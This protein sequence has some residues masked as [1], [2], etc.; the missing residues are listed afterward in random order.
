MV[1]DFFN[2]SLLTRQ[3]W[4]FRKEFMWI[5]VF[6]MI[7]NVLMLTPTIYMLQLYARVLKSH[8]DLTLLALT[9]FMLL[10]FLV[11]AF[12]EW[13]RSRLLV[14]IGVRL[15]EGLNSLVFNAS[16]QAF[17]SNAGKNVAQTF[18]DLASIRQ[19]LTTNGTIAFFDVPWTPVYIGVM[20][21]LHPIL[22]WLALLFA[23]VQLVLTWVSNM[24]V[25]ASIELAANEGTKGYSFLQGKLRNIEPVHAMG[26]TANLRSRWSSLHDDY[27]A[28]SSSMSDRQHRLE[29]LNKLVRYSISSLTLA[30]GAILVIRGEL[31]VGSM[32]AANVLMSKAL[33][34]LDL[35]IATLQPF[36]KARASFIRLEKLLEDF[37]ERKPGTKML[38]DPLGEITLRNLSVDVPGREQPILKDISTMI[39]AGKVTVILGPTGSGKSTLARCL[40][41]V[42]PG[43]CD[44][45]LI[46]GEPVDSWDR[47]QLGRNIGYLPQ[48]IEL[49]EGTFA[50]NISRFSEVDSQKVIEAAKRAGI[51]DMIV[52]FPKGYD[53]PIGEAGGLLSAGQRQRLGLARAMYGN[54]SIYVLDEPNANLDEIGERALIDAVKNLKA[55]GKTVIM[56]SHRTGILEAADLVMLM[57]DGRVDRFG[58]KQDVLKQ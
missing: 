44:Q 37:P 36:V 4:L 46:D 5:G 38:Q 30:A 33:Q 56:I 53:T 29:S 22:G 23:V 19:F 48:D 42:W 17:L 3:L 1:P 24:S 28:R 14:R 50:E 6:S 8:N 11:M 2:R 54:P 58:T 16:F 39:P 15:D 51:H 25:K 20:F 45:V 7:A 40:V 41:G 49:L 21:L 57:A 52:R 55:E 43:I 13:L 9:I 27:L 10:F 26:M 47:E 34:P 31:Q 12:S 35:I 32:V 18:S